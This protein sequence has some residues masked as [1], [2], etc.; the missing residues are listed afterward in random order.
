VEVATGVVVGHDEPAVPLPKMTH[1]PLEALEQA[2]LPALLRSPCV[3][4]FSG[5]RDSSAVLAV[6]LRVARREGLAEPVAFTRRWPTHP[7]TD[8]SYWQELVVKALGVRD[9]ERVELE[10]SDVIGPLARP[11]LRRR[12]VLW[13]PFAHPLPVL[14]ARAAGGSFVTG[15]GGDEILGSRRCSTFRNLLSPKTRITRRQVERALV[16]LGPRP[17]REWGVRHRYPALAFWLVPD[18]R[19]DFLRSFVEDQASEPLSWAASLRWHVRSKSVVLGTHNLEVLVG[20]NG[21]V[22]FQPLLDPGFISAFARATGPFGFPDRT[23]AMRSVF[24]DLL[25]DE[26]L[27]R[28]TKAFTTSV[29]FGEC[30]RKFMDAWDGKGVDSSMVDIESLRQAWSGPS[31][32]VNTGLLLQQAWIESEE[33]NR[34]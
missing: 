15:E 14:F 24:H 19:R 20:E 16:S 10:E 21:A 8:E 33:A 25:P 3:V 34:P 22:M 17:V 30:S 18:L 28:N 5:G 6:A 4:A 9:W 32:P 2:V 13:P 1:T 31:P 11:S 26:L 29:V 12:G 27:R 7:D 23:A